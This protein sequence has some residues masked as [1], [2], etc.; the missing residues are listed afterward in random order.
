MVPR[1]VRALFE[2]LQTRRSEPPDGM[3]GAS[4]A[5][6]CGDEARGVPGVVVRVSFLQIYKEKIFD[7]LNPISSVSQREAAR[8]GEDLAEYR[9]PTASVV[10]RYS[11]TQLFAVY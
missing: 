4:G 6:G 5:D 7:L 3:N 9:G 2:K 11:T 8:A 10:C 1:A